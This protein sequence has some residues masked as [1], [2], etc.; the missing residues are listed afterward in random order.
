MSAI[1]QSSTPCLPDLSISFM[2]IKKAVRLADRTRTLEL[3]RDIADT[4]GDLTD[5][6]LA[7]LTVHPVWLALSTSDVVT[8]ERA[9]KDGGRKLLRKL[10]TDMFV[11][12]H[13]G[14]RRNPITWMGLSRRATQKLDH[15]ANQ[16]STQST[17]GKSHKGNRRHQRR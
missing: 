14:K 11:A 3:I 9:A 13:K 17:K 4:K 2:E 8:L 15:D 6:L 16:S 5:E 7:R 10:M 1:T 12:L